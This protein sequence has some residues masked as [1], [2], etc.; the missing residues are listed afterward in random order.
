MLFLSLVS[1]SPGGSEAWEVWRWNGPLAI[2]RQ[3]PEGGTTWSARRGCGPLGG[4]TP[5]PLLLAPSAL[6]PR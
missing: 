6:D 2:S 5:A 4:A 1:W 3:N